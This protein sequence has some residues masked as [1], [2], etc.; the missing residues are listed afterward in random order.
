MNSIVTKEISVA[1]ENCKTLRQVKT[2]C[3]QQSYYVV[4]NISTYDKTK[5]DY[6]S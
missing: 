1:A 6:M 5:V 4:T 3:M 2:M